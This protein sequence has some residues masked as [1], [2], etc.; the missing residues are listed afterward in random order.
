[1]NHKKLKLV[2]DSLVNIA[3]SKK[4]EDLRS[5]FVSEKNWMTDYVVVIGVLNKIQAK[6][7][8]TD[9][10]KYISELDDSDDLFNEARVSGTPE[11]GWLI[12]D[13]NSIV[14]HFVDQENRDFYNIDSLLELQGDVY[15]Y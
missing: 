1:M 4:A 3:D 13:L 10:E 9:I 11:S 2:V 12:L 15:H 14:I 6:A 7:I 8:L 5:Y